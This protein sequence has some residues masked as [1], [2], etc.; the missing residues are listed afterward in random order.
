[1]SNLFEEPIADDEV[2]IIVRKG[3][4]FATVVTKR[5][6]PFT[7]PDCALQLLQDMLLPLTMSPGRDPPQETTDETTHPRAG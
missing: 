7:D 1:M 3:E 2:M 4:Q 6:E 5:T